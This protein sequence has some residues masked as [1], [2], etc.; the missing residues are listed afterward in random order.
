MS[1]EEVIRDALPVKMSKVRRDQLASEIA[2]AL[3]EAGWL[4]DG[5]CTT[6]AVGPRA[7]IPVE[8]VEVYGLT[9]KL[10]AL[11]DAS[12]ISHPGGLVTL[13]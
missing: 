8:T 13:G 5:E 6:V 4:L 12:E 11:G 7:L 3:A 10:D 1:P 9:I 2:D